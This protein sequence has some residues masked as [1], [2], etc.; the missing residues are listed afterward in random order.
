MTTMH[1]RHRRLLSAN[2][3]TTG[4]Q[5]P[6]AQQNGVAQRHQRNLSDLEPRDDDLGCMR[7]IV[8]AIGPAVLLWMVGIWLFTWFVDLLARTL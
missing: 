8:W 3:R 1:T 7:G 5:L 6:L 4:P 2:G